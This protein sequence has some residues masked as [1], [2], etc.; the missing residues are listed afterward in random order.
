[1][2]DYRALEERFMQLIELYEDRFW[3]DS[4][5]KFRRSMKR[6]GMIGTS[7]CTPSR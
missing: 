6:H 7:N 2:A 1:M 4:V 3:L 5:S